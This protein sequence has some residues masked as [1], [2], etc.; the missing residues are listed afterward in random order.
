MSCFAVFDGHGGPE[1]SDY[2]ARRFLDVLTQT[3]NWKKGAP[4]ECAGRADPD[5][6][7]TAHPKAPRTPPTDDHSAAL[8]EAFLAIDREVI[9]PDG[10]KKLNEIARDGERGVRRAEKGKPPTAGHWKKE[11]AGRGC[12]PACASPRALDDTYLAFSRP[13]SHASSLL[14]GDSGELEEGELEGLKA[15][16]G[17]VRARLVCSTRA[18]CTFMPSTPPPPPVAAAAAT[19]L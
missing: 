15:D 19:H 1:V 12:Y 7:D 14:Q 18:D 4:R 13:R 9:T 10:Q 17:M 16:V 8:I 5:T 6:G 2:V 3:E 11:G